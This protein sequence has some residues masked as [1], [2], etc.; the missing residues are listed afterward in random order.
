M[1]ATGVQLLMSEKSYPLCLGHTSKD[2]IF[3]DMI[4][5]G[6]NGYVYDFFV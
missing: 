2:F 4:E 6:L 1:E 3:N 5:T